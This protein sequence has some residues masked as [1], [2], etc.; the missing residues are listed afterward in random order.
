MPSPL[1][2]PEIFSLLEDRGFTITADVNPARVDDTR[3]T[4]NQSFVTFHVS[5][6]DSRSV[7]VLRGKMTGA[8]AE[9]MDGA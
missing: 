9:E 8:L 5:K 3:S 1:T 2:L 4:E 7:S 6:R